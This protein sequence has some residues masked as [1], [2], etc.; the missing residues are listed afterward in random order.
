MAS[1]LELTSLTSGTSSGLHETYCIFGCD[2]AICFYHE[3][4]VQRNDGARIV[5]KRNACLTCALCVVSGCDVLKLLGVVCEE[6]LKSALSSAH[7][8]MVENL[9]F[10]LVCPTM[11]NPVLVVFPPRP[12]LEDYCVIQ[13]RR[14]PRRSRPLQQQ[15]EEEEE[16]EVLSC[17]PSP[18]EKAADSADTA[19]PPAL[20]FDPRP[21]H[22]CCT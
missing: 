14:T 6:V 11:R 1:Q 18:Q 15:E 16:E 22:S 4:Y 8:A 17:S 12:V 19:R 20:L 9:C 10:L 3:I 5:G 21:S 7:H 2:G 13:G